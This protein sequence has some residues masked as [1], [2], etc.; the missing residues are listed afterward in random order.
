[1]LI[2]SELYSQQDSTVTVDFILN[3]IL[4]EATIEKEDSQI[5]DLIEQLLENPININTAAKT[6]LMLVPFMDIESA[7]NIINHRKKH[8]KFFSTREIKMIDGLSSNISKTL[9]LSDCLQ[10]IE[11]CTVNTFNFSFN[12]FL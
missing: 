4:D 12:I 9:L 11:S 6:D 5:Y 2:F 8:G 7:A 3:N 1:M 10:Y